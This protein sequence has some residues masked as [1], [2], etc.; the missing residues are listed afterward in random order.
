ML[1][2]YAIIY[3]PHPTKDQMERGE[4]PKQVLVVPITSVLANNDK[5]AQ[6]L[7]SRAIPDTYT[8]KLDQL[9]IAVRP[10]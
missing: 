4:K 10:F 8:D 3:K 7:A 2:E 6:M 1:F 5:E 9:D